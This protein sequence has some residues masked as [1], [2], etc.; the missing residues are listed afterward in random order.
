MIKNIWNLLKEI[1]VFNG[2]F[3]CEREEGMKYKTKEV[4]EI[5]QV[6]RSWIN[7]HLRELGMKHLTRGTQVEYFENEIIDWLNSNARFFKK[8]EFLDL[9]KYA[10]IDE[11]GDWYLDVTEAGILHREDVYKNFLERILPADYFSLHTEKIN[12]RKRG[13]IKWQEIEYTIDSFKQLK[14]IN[15]LREGKSEELA[16]RE[17]YE[18][19]MIKVEIGGRRWFIE[20]ED[21]PEYAILMPY[22][23]QD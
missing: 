3:K 17:I 23:Y 7:N 14:T 15:E 20:A 21:R 2:K 16:Y 5:L 6:S 13:L 22:G 9:T 19:G 1:I 12:P 18:K 8:T 10:S 4:S 11:I